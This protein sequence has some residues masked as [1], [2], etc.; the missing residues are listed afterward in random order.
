M[1]LFIAVPLPVDLTSRA[2]ALLPGALPGLKRVPPEL[3]HVTLAFLGW[4]PD[5]QLAA[6][7]AAATAA[8]GA[9][10]PFRLSFGAAA[11]FPERGRARVAWLGIGDGAAELAALAADLAAA[12]RARQL[13][14]DERPF[15]PHLTLAR[16]RESASLAEARTVTAAVAGLGVPDLC[17]GAERIAVVQSVLTPKGPRYAERASAPLGA[18]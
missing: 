4:T 18:P 5:E 15:T 10:R 17:C 7:V 2:A 9:H 8:A 11:T 3:M 13:R 14:F 6:A 16:V 1:R 12:L